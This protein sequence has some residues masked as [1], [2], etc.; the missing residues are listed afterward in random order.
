MGFYI[1]DADKKSSDGLAITEWNNLSNAVAG[2]SGL[3][4]ALNPDDQ[5]GIGMKKPKGTLE[6]ARGTAHDGTAVFGG[7]ERRSH[8]NHS[9]DEHTYIRG[10]KKDSNVFINDNGG[11]VGIGKKNPIEKLDVSGNVKATNFIGDGLQLTNLNVDATGLILAI[12]K[13]AK[14]GIGTTKPS[15]KL[16][17]NGTVKAAKFIGDGS[18][19]T[20][21]RVGAT[22]LILATDKGAKVGIGMK[23]PNGTLEVARGT[24]NDGT[25]VFGGT[26][27]RSHFNYS[28]DEHTYIRGGK[29]GSNVFIND[30]GG[31]VGIG[32]D[33]PTAKL[34]VNGDI[35]TAGETPILFKR[36]Q[37]ANL[38]DTGLSSKDYNA[39]I[40][41]FNA[42]IGDINEHGE[43]NMIKVYMFTGA[44]NT[45]WI[46]ADFASEKDHHEKW[47]VDVMF[48][49]KE[50]S[51]REG[52]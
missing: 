29:K 8:F 25:A 48:V 26:E 41:G 7:T 31:N 27:R 10:G 23:K 3:T 6:V 9:T 50:L 47:T 37:N 38:K 20:N 5:V 12:T 4:L 16:E 43:V 34:D 14:V 52:Y 45:W 19:L 36:Y 32:T 30:D 2:N 40:V 22:G 24:A 42:G 49:R 15:R 11:N 13:S 44:N 1:H 39:A 46:T 51:S 17:V 18:Q 33:R 35:K 28:T 21:L